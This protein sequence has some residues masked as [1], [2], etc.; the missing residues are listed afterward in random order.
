MP[1]FEP[2]HITSRKLFEAGEDP[3]RALALGTS[4]PDWYDFAYGYKNAADLLVSRLNDRGVLAEH[5]CLPI[6]FLYRHYVELSL[7]AIL[8]DLDE[9]ADILAKLPDKHLVLPLWK[10]VRDA[11]LDFDPSQ[12]SDWLDRAEA[13]IAELDQLDPQSFTFRYPVDKSGA[14]T[15]APMLVNME[16]VRDVMGELAIVL[17]GAGAYLSEHIQLKRELEAKYYYDAYYYP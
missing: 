15:L 5:V 11:L 6:L 1:H 7:K 13:L 4:T 16:H 3:Q 9:L 10:Q 8:I 17:D 12:E 2:P 14:V